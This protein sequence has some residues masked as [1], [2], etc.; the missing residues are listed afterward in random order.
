MTNQHEFDGPG[1]NDAGDVGDEAFPPAAADRA[2]TP[3]EEA[4]A[5]QARGDVDLGAVTEEYEHMTELGAN[6]Q[7]E[8]QI[9]SD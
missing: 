8:G 6:V 5:E 1:G 4:A 7:G 3:D 9:E 2:P